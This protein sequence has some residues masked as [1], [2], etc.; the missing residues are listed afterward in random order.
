MNVN[1]SLE[2][3]SKTGSLAINSIFRQ[4]KLDLM[5]RF[6]E[7]KSINTKLKHSEIAKEVGCSRN[8]LQR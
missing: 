8:T 4:Y 1:F 5:A 2:Q 3:T 6:M 7:N